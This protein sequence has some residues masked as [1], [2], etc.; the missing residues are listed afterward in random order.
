[1]A[2][3]LHL[4]N[5]KRKSSVWKVVSTQRLFHINQRLLWFMNTRFWRSEAPFCIGSGTAMAGGLPQGPPNSLFIA[6]VL[7]HVPVAEW[8]PQGQQWELLLGGVGCS[9]CGFA[10]H[11]LI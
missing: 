6:G 2:V 8:G 1:M 9:G 7:A 10:P 4:K 3:T 11:L 5:P